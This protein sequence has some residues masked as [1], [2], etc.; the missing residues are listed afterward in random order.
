MSETDDEVERDAQR[1]PG[2]LIIGSRESATRGTGATAPS[3]RVYAR[4]RCGQAC[5]QCR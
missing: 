5:E 1:G 4:E 2:K 3:I